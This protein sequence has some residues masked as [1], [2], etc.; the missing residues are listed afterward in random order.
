MV[1]L[2]V[3]M[4][5]MVTAVALSSSIFVAAAA[6]QH[7][8]TVTGDSQD[9]GRLAI[10]DIVKNAQ[11][12][13]MLT[14][15][16]VFVQMSSVGTTPVLVQPV[17]GL[18]GSTG[19][20]AIG[21][22]AA[23]GTTACV[24]VGL[25]ASTICSGTDDLWLIV[26]D[27]HAMGE[28]CVTAGANTTVVVS[29]DA[30]S[31]TGISVQCAPVVATG[32]TML[33]TNMLTGALLSNVTVTPHALP[34]PSLLTYNEA[35][36]NYSD[37]PLYGYQIGDTVFRVNLVHYFV[38]TDPS[39]IPTLYKSVNGSLGASAG[40]YP[41]EGRPFKDGTTALRLQPYVE[42]LQ[43]AFGLDSNSGSPSYAGV[44]P[45]SGTPQTF[46]NGFSP[47]SGFALSSTG[48]PP[49][50]ALRALR[51][52]VVVRSPNPT[53]TLGTGNVNTSQNVPLTVEG[54]TPGTTPDG[55][56]RT[57]YT[58]TIALPNLMPAG[59]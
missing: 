43:I 2:M 23:V 7:N 58:R 36:S 27:P 1:E 24:G 25:P 48:V 45:Y 21:A 51:V 17:F 15:G 41:T 3:A 20:G 54:H 53:V 4:A 42:D 8:A 29:S 13:G 16:G 39:G 31:A 55:L 59:M 12:A 10:N 19:A 22:G 44:L 49:P 35:A 50:S 30:G 34:T 14:P 5:I 6:V 9:N 11:R 52:N 38:A 33:A 28:S 26:P 32:D 57:L 18:D 40:P 37:S 47:T 56:L 46:V